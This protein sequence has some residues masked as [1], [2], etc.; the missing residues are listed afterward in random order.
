LIQVFAQIVRNEEAQDEKR[1]E[2]LLVLVL[3]VLSEDQVEARVLNLVEFW[4]Q[5]VLSEVQVLVRS[6]QNEALVVNHVLVQIY[7]P[8]LKSV[9]NHFLVHSAVVQGEAQGEK[10]FEE[11]LVWVQVVQNVDLLLN[12]VVY[13]AYLPK[14]SVYYVE[15]QVLVQ[16]SLNE[17]A[18]DA[19]QDGMRFEEYQVLV[20]VD[21]SEILSVSRAY[22]PKLNAVNQVLNHSGV[23]QDEVRVYLRVEIQDEVQDEMQLSGVRALVQVYQR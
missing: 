18:Q 9:V 8:I 12:Q 21:L 17:E 3:V 15:V 13:L 4:V 20:P 14:T 7:L 11:L 16:V 22:L 6:G 23:V 10:R 1:F 2:E 19:V 5:V